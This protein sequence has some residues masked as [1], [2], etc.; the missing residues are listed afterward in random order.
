MKACMKDYFLK[1]DCKDTGNKYKNINVFIEG[2]CVTTAV[3]MKDTALTQR[4]TEK[5]FTCN[6]TDT[7]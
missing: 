1:T 3:F 4:L 7:K 2:L 5:D 6:T